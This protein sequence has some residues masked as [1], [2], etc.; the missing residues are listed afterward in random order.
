MLLF[1]D[2]K[3][4][5]DRKDAGMQLGKVLEEFKGKDALVLGIPRGGVEVGYYVAKHINAELSTVVTKKLP[6]PGQ[7]ELGFGSMAEDGS[8]FISERIRSEISKDQFEKIV[9]RQ[10]VEIDR[11]VK[12]YRKGRPAPDMKGRVVILVDDGISTAT[13]LV[14]AVD[15]CKKKGA[16]KVIV[17][18]PVSAIDRP[19]ELNKIDD[20]IILERPDF[21]YAIGQVYDEF[22][23]L[24]DKEVAEILK[25]SDEL[26]K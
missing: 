11:R 26:K 15:M 5:K 8:I 9:E 20:Y 7:D 19:K 6:Y 23:N 16:S 1:S 12:L 14:P 24:E 17:A 22:G 25:K 21:F 18:A 4:F 13:S 10:K 3:K 2:K